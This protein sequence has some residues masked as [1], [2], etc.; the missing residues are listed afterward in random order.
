MHPHPRP[1]EWRHPGIAATLNLAVSC[2]DQVGDAAMYAEDGTLKTEALEHFA[3]RPGGGSVRTMI[4]GAWR[5]TRETVR[6]IST[7]AASAGTGSR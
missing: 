2:L 6:L 7:P 1:Y 5:P 3:V 4:H